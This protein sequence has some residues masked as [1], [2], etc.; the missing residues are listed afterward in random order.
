MTQFLFSNNTETVLAANALFTD[1]TI[2]VATGTGANF[3]APISGQVIVL[4]L[5]AALNQAITEIVYCTNI[6]GDV[7]TITRAQENTIAHNWYVGDF[8][9]NL[10]TAGSANQFAQVNSGSTS[11][12]PIPT[13]IGQF[14]YDTTLGYPIYCNQITPS[15]VWHNSQ[16]S[17]V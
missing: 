6:T 8:V 3:P 15:V 17:P 1:T 2:T 9:A 10:F 13:K 14:Y 7:M 4:T 5:S 12:R 11:N 16:G